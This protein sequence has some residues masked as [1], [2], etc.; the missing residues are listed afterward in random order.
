MTQAA[1]TKI[2][3]IINLLTKPIKQLQKL[4]CKDL[5]YWSFLKL[6]MVTMIKYDCILLL[7]FFEVYQTKINI[8]LNMSFGC[9]KIYFDPNNLCHVNNWIQKECM[10]KKWTF[11]FLINILWKLWKCYFLLLFIKVKQT[12]LDTNNNNINISV[13][14]GWFCLSLN[15]INITSKNLTLLFSCV[16]KMSVKNKKIL[17]NDLTTFSFNFCFPGAGGVNF[18][19]VDLC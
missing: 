15:N 12:F 13:Q 5:F 16:D 19:F 4:S 6:K 1:V 17:K 14:N 3:K 2:H 18:R 8:N 7:L 10:Y 11:L 9:L